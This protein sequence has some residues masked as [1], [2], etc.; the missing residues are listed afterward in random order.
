MVITKTPYRVSLFGGGTDFPNW[1]K[2]FG[3]KVVALAIDKYCQLDIKPIPINSRF[4]YKVIYSKTEE[5]FQIS[6]IEHPAVREAL[7]LYYPNFGLEIRHRGDLPARSG[8][9]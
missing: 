2:S 7:K 5:T 4:K 9:G 8:I 1:F 3:G 6:E